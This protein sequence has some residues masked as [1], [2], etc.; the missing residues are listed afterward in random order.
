MW[1]VLLPMKVRL[2][3]QKRLLVNNIPNSKQNLSD[4]LQKILNTIGIGSVFHHLIKSI[5]SVFRLK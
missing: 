4:K 5:R 1:R 2:L 3:C